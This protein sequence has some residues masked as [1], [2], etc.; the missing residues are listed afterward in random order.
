MCQTIEK[1]EKVVSGLPDVPV[2]F[3][4]IKYRSQSA[5]EYDINGE[6]ISW[7]VFNEANISIAHTHITKGSV[8]NMHRHEG[9]YEIIIVLSGVLEISVDRERRILNAHDWI[10]ITKNQ[11]HEARALESTWIVAITVPRD[12]GFPE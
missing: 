11:P 6:M 9:S 1:L 8:V 5:T 7:P 12:E 2:M 3:N 10:H 4:M